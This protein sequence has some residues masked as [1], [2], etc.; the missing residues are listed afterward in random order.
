[1]RF[2]YTDTV[3]R[4][5]PVTIQLPLRATSCEAVDFNG[6]PLG[7]PAIRLDGN[8]ADFEIR[9][10]EIVTLRFKAQA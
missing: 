8:Q 10:W 2:A 7:S 1:M 6:Q 3:G 5:G 4:G 9:P